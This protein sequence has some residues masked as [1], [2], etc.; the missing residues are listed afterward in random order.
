MKKCPFCAEEIQDEAQKFRYCGE[1]LEPVPS[2]GF[3]AQ[4]T[5]VKQKF[6]D[7]IERLRQRIDPRPRLSNLPPI[8][9]LELM[10]D[11]RLFRLRC[12][13]SEYL[14]YLFFDNRH[15]AVR[16]FLELCGLFYFFALGPLLLL[17]V[18]SVYIWRALS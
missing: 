14:W 16:K 2:E 17:I 12:E 6:I 3:F 8:E 13:V 7:S 15:S 1:W 18:I 11:S 10:R 4:K 9:A 5:V